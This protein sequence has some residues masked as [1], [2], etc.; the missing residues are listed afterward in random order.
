ML[1]FL[2]GPDSY[3]RIQKLNEIVENF[4]KRQSNLSHERFDVSS[5]DE[6]LKFQ[7]FARNR[8]IFDP[9]RLAILDGFD[10]SPFRK[11]GEGLTA[12]NLKELKEI[13]K[14]NH[15]NEDLMI[16]LNSSSKP[17]TGFTVL[18]KEPTKVQEF[19]ALKGVEVSNFIK[20]TA[21]T[22]GFTINASMVQALVQTFGGNTWG[23]VTE[24]EKMTLANDQ[25]EP[26]LSIHKP[27]DN[28][29][30]LINT[31]KYGRSLKDRLVALEV[32]LSDRKD[33]PAKVFNM[34]AYR[35]RNQK[36]ADALAD[37]DVAVKSGKLEYEEVLLDYTLN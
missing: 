14:A 21:K 36:E 5:D 33:E 16:I 26:V 32:I 8:S 11:K 3:Q 2:Y 10:P 19:P 15:K 29:F 37:Y 30:P 31:L 17:A 20:K 35:L 7:T 4:R 28:F 18:V 27:A 23:I 22:L 9:V 24:L 34:L 25:T 6:F 1:I 13:L 12:S